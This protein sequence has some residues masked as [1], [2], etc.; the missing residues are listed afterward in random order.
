MLPDIPLAAWRPEIVGWAEDI[1][2]Y[3]KRVAEELPQNARFV[4][5]GVAHG[6]SAIYMAE[7]LTILGRQDVELW[8]VD[9]WD[10]SWF[11]ESIVQTLARP[12]LAKYVDMLRIV[13]CESLRASG[14]FADDTIDHVFIDSDHGYESMVKQIRRWRTKVKSG[15]IISGHDYS[16][17]DWPGV[18][19]AVDEE[20]GSTI[21]GRPTRTVWEMEIT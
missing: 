19:D 7:Q 10:G 21:V 3:Y 13:R 6:R 14:L 9:S 1:L 20:L 16:K 2:P 8:C 15:G 18:V 5:I 11:R 17:G 4:E 12:E